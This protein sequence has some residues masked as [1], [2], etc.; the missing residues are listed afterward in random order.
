MGIKSFDLTR[1]WC[2]KKEVTVLPRALPDLL[3]SADLFESVA[4][5]IY[6]TKLRPVTVLNSC[7]LFKRK[8]VKLG[9]Q[10][11]F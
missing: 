8:H 1:L 7:Q 2:C 3:L 10:K 4:R 9:H 11:V 5:K 6:T